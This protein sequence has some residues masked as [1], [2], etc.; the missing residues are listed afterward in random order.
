MTDKELQKLKRVDLLEVLLEQ[1]RT[2]D[3]LRVQLQAKDNEIASLNKKLEERK[4]EIQE[5]GSI[6]EAAIK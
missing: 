1:S 6:A 4:I 3:D 2:I 5:A